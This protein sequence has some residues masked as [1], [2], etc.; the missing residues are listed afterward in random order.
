M[1]R[2]HS[3]HRVRAKSDEAHPRHADDRKRQDDAHRAKVRQKFTVH[4][5][6]LNLCVKVPASSSVDNVPTETCLRKMGKFC[7]SPE[8]VRGVTKKVERCRGKPSG[9]GR[10]SGR[11]RLARR[12]MFLEST[13]SIRGPIPAGDVDREAP[14]ARNLNESNSRCSCIIGHPPPGRDRGDRVRAPIFPHWHVPCMWT[15]AISVPLPLG[16][17]PLWR[18]AS[19]RASAHASRQW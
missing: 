9:V 1:N 6:P 19:F 8:R 3:A 17:P 16:P 18:S 14:A 5:L 13:L 12:K 10:S 2:P 11:F 15:D 4:T 7:K